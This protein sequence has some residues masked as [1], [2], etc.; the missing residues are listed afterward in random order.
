MFTKS[1][2]MTKEKIA[3]ARHVFK[4]H[5]E[6]HPDAAREGLAC[7]RNAAPEYLTNLIPSDHP[8]RKAALRLLT[9]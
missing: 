3:E 1:E 6:S 7:L 8:D 9:E 2:W 4:T 5:I